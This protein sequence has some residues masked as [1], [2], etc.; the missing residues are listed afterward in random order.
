MYNGLG[1]IVQSRSL[2]RACVIASW[3]MRLRQAQSQSYYTLHAQGNRWSSCSRQNRQRLEIDY[4]AL[5]IILNLE[6][7]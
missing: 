2:G 6:R 7:H 5:A 1:R 4:T 3:A